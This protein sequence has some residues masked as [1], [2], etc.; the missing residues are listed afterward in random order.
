MALKKKNILVYLELFRIFCLQ[1]RWH[2][3]WTICMQNTFLRTLTSGQPKKKHDHVFLSRLQRIR[4]TVL[5]LNLY[6]RYTASWDHKGDLVCP[7]L[8][9]TTVAVST[10]RNLVDGETKWKLFLILGRLSSAREWCMQAIVFFNSLQ[11]RLKMQWDYFT[12]EAHSSSR[13]IKMSSF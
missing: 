3:L 12:L 9:T 13:L 1:G 7:T 5:T 6:E 11:F 2:I 4:A 8:S 10:W